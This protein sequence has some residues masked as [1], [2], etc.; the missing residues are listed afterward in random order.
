[1]YSVKEGTHLYSPSPNANNYRHITLPENADDDNITLEQITYV[2]QNGVMNGRLASAPQDPVRRKVIFMKDIIRRTGLQSV[3]G[4]SDADFMQ[5]NKQA[6]S[7][8]LNLFKAKNSVVN[9][10][11]DT[12]SKDIRKASNTLRQ[13]LAR[14]PSSMMAMRNM[15]I[16][17]VRKKI[18]NEV[19]PHFANHPDLLKI[20]DSMLFKEWCDIK[21]EYKGRTY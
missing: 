12:I 11:L 15:Y 17:T 20:V 14:R 1:M 10:L 5:K 16:S 2:R 6:Y 4:S 19:S 9:S 7:H 13:D 21:S 3:P 18:R 8:A